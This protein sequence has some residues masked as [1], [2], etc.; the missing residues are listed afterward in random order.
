MKFYKRMLTLICGFLIDYFSNDGILGEAALI[1][2]LSQD[3]YF[4]TLL[5]NKFH[6]GVLK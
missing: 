6:E 1:P 2:E 3:V 4:V 5:A